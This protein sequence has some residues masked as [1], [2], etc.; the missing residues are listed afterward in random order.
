MSRWVRAWVRPTEV[1][2]AAV[3]PQGDVAVGVDAVVADAG[4]GVVVAAGGRE[5]LGEGVV[6]GG[7]GGAV[8]RARCGRWWL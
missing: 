7:G 8:G 4:V 3:D 5:G 2:E 6:G 1:V